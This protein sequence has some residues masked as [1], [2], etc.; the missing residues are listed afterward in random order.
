MA[1][2]SRGYQTVVVLTASNNS[3]INVLL[4]YDGTVTTEALAETAFAAWATD[5]AVVGAGN[6]KSKSHQHAYYN[7]AW[8]IPSSQDAEAGERAIV[9]IGDSVDP[10]KTHVLNI[11][12][13]ITSVVYQGT[14]GEA[15]DEVKV[16]SNTELNN[17]V[18]NWVSG[19]LTLSDG[20]KGDGT[21][22]R[23]KRSGS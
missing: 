12:F 13:A 23:G 2:V 20:E 11:P 6:I 7:D 1:Y 5:Y 14:T 21:I 9:V 15:R 22:F 18:E 4:K 16:T 8:S 17:Y 3:N 19:P 10:T